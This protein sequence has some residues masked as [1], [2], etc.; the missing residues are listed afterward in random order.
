MSVFTSLKESKIRKINVSL[1]IVLFFT[2]CFSIIGCASSDGLG[3]AWESNDTVSNKNVFEFRGKSFTLT[4]YG[5]VYE[6][7]ALRRNESRYEWGEL[8]TNNEYDNKEFLGE[9]SGT[10][11]EWRAMDYRIISKGTFSVSD[12]KIEFTLSDGSVK[13]LRFSRTENTIDINNK[14][15]V[16]RR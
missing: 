8:C 4:Q 5:S 9:R 13:V 1:M 2:V 7:F 12:D 6:L 14:R 3:G 11:G 15:F 10:G 16:R